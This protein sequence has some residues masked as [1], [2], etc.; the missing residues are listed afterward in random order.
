MDLS[1]QTIDD[2]YWVEAGR[3]LAG[4]YPGARQDAE[5]RRKLRWLL[6]QG[7]DVVIDLT[8][9]GEG[10]LRPYAALLADE[11]AR[12][13]RAV[14][15]QR[16]PIPDLGTIS[17]EAMQALQQMLETHLHAGR[18]VYV[19]CWGGIGRTGTVVGCY[20]ARHGVAGETA[21]LEIE[22]MRQVVPSSRPSPE[23]NEQRKM[24]FT[25]PV[26]Q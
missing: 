3:L 23:T 22:Q 21:L 13:E 12:Q 20:L 8:E 24:V 17:V 5:A 11:A 6:A 25:W 15:H 2:A 16:A 19:H 9:A 1:E 26:N 7:I 18:R 4:E 10:Q 14:E